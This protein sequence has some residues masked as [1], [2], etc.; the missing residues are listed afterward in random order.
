VPGHR[1]L[2]IGDSLV[3]AARARAAEIL[4]QDG[5]S[6][7]WAEASTGDA[8]ALA[9]AV[10]RLVAAFEPDLAC[11]GAGL[12]SREAYADLGARPE[13]EARDFDGYETALVEIADRLRRFC[14]RQ[15]VFVG[16]GP[17]Q[18]ARFSA[19]HG[20]P[21]LGRKVNARVASFNRVAFE[22][23][24]RVNVMT[25]G[26][27]RSLGPRV[28]EAVGPD[29]LTLTASGI[30]LAASDLADAVYSVV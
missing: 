6:V 11:F 20:D 12:A 29:G 25:K 23:L 10:E 28:D 19:A 26:L 4:G 2:M 21:D 5:L 27:E 17:V 30:E 1:V 18:E 14:G 22:A 24:G 8:E 13:L 16:A 15:V 3:V 9:A 7:V